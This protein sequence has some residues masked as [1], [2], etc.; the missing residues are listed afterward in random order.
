MTGKKGSLLHLQASP[1][2]G[3]IKKTITFHLYLTLNCQNANYQLILLSKL[4]SVVGCDM[5]PNLCLEWILS[6]RNVVSKKAI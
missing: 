4:L 3:S 5:D 6:W 1:F 2:G